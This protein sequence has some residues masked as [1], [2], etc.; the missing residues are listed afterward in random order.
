MTQGNT[1]KGNLTRA[2]IRAPFDG[3]IISHETRFP[4]TIDSV[5]AKIDNMKAKA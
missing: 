2:H 3:K 5:K 4:D 1:T